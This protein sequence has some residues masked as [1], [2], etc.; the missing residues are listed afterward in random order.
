MLLLQILV[1]FASNNKIFGV[2]RLSAE[3]MGEQK[4]WPVIRAQILGDLGGSGAKDL[5]LLMFFKPQ[6]SKN[7]G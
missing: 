1:A 6:I 3:V 7:I 4:G 5:C 2:R